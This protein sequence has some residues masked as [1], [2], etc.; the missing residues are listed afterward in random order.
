MLLQ[1]CS[2]I[3]DSWETKG[4]GFIKYQVD[5]SADY[6]IELDEDDVL[7]PNYN[8]HYF[9]ATTRIEESG[10]KDAFSIM[11]YRPVLGENNVVEQYSWFSSEGS[12]HGVIFGDQSIVHFDQK[13]DSTW[14]A[15]LDL[16]AENCTTGECTDSLPRIHITG[17][18]RYWI[19]VDER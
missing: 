14:T 2:G 5:G 1:A 3:N 9:Q 4:G 12:P 19:P 11:V 15:N 17:R 10:R 8:R 13:D 7:L 16:Y 6:T 18:L